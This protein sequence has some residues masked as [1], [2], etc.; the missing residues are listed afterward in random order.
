MASA[1]SQRV[2][3][4]AQTRRPDAVWAVLLR[5]RGRALRV[6]CFR[7][8]SIRKFHGVERK[9]RATLRGSKPGTEET[10]MAAET[11]RTAA[12]NFGKPELR[13]LARHSLCFLRAGWA[14]ECARVVEQACPNFW[15]HRHV[16]FSFE[17]EASSAQKTSI[18]PGQ[19]HET[20]KNELLSGA[21]SLGL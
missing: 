12:D 3:T 21:G 7:D 19:I 6:E 2:S 17:I 18:L 13:A 20:H 15:R 14:R 11:A 5:R 16:D 10:Q 8:C 1:A 9:A 4:V